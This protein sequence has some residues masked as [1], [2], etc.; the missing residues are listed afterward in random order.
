MRV[1][2]SPLGVF[3]LN[4]GAFLTLAFGFHLWAGSH[5]QFPVTVPSL[6]WP[7]VANY[8]LALLITSLLFLLRYK[9][10]HNLGFIFMGS[11]FLKFA[12]FFIGFYPFYS[13]DDVVSSTEFAQFFVPY[14]IS[15]TIETIFLIR[16]VN[17][18]D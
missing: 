17:E 1:R 5:F 3:A 13:Q 6:L 11:S 16:V 4:L 7:Y 10:T 8:I 12:V 9:Q 2:N 14:A 18:M 15:L